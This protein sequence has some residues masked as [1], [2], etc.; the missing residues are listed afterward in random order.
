M[1]SWKKSKGVWKSRLQ[2]REDGSA[3]VELMTIHTK[4][5]KALRWARVGWLANAQQEIRATRPEGRNKREKIRHRLQ[6]T[7]QLN[8]Y[9]RCRDWHEREIEFCDWW[10]SL[11]TASVNGVLVLLPVQ[12]TD[13]TEAQASQVR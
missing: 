5:E 8:E 4:A 7:N 13:S 1:E 3:D 9:Q 10:L 2:L 6:L 11:K 12:V